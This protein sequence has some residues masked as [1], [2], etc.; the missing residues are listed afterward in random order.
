MQRHD[1]IGRFG[2]G[3]VACACGGLLA[4][5]T[6]ATTFGQCGSGGSCFE[7]HGPG[8]NDFDCCMAVCG[9]DSFCCNI[10]WDGFC[11]SE[12]QTYC[13]AAPILG[14]FVHPT[15]GNS[16]FILDDATWSGAQNGAAALGGHLVSIRDAAENEWVLQ[17]VLG[18]GLGPNYWIGLNDI[19]N[20]GNFVWAG[21]QAV[22]YLNWLP[23]QPDSSG[24][25][26]AVHVLDSL[27][28][29]NDLP[30]AAVR[31]SV[32]EVEQYFCGDPD[33]GSCTTIHVT[34]FCSDS[35]CCE[36][37]CSIDPYCCN[38]QWD[39]L[40]ANEGAVGCSFQQIAGPIVNP[41]TG[42]RHTMFSTGGWLYA[43]IKATEMGQSIVTVRS[44]Q[45]NEFLRRFFGQSVPGFGVNNIWV[46]LNDVD[47]EGTFVWTS[48]EPFTFA[49]WALG[50]PTNSWFEDS[51]LLAGS[52]GA[53]YL[54][55]GSNISPSVTESGGFA[56]CGSGGSCTSMHG[57]G[58]D[59]EACC[60]LICEFD[61]YCCTTM[62]DEDCVGHAT[63]RCSPSVIMGPFVNPVTKHAYYG[64]SA[65]MWTEAERFANQLGGHL[66]VPN[67]PAENAWIAAN[68]LQIPNPLSSALIGV[69]DQMIE[70]VF[71][72]LDVTGPNP[73]SYAPWLL[74]EPN[75]QENED[76][77]HMQTSGGWNDIT[78]WGVHPSVVEVPCLGD[79]DGDGLVGAVDLGILL[80]AWGFSPAMDL[81]FDGKVGAPD[82]AILLGAWGPCDTSNCCTVHGFGGCDQPGCTQCVCGI[83]PYCCNVQWDSY[84]VSESAIQC[85]GACQ[86]GG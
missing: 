3:A 80:G 83:D 57:P 15:N 35:D 39:G 10:N 18:L 5:G 26:D 65:A 9:F 11:V 6:V 1:T 8:C 69:H 29:W 85:N 81:T 37:V 78:R 75:N 2:R 41:A 68:F 27:G 24:N 74:G 31:I 7:L 12:A 56:V 36:Y 50:E 67:T 4:M 82:L 40:C 72:A 45:E 63:L 86:C 43:D 19:A 64:V 20:E 21:G 44:Q 51:V 25:E 61:S 84:C 77:V 52:T 38:S 55:P 76:M 62:W 60:N 48:G 54:T 53:W 70:G 46:G 28:Q 16:Y 33:A 34:P 66:A 17:T 79:M 42:R 59:E 23:G 14:P 58:C 30:V 22:T 47:V 13:T 49:N 32:A 71:Q 73:V